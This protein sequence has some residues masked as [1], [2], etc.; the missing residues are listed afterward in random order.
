MK[1]PTKK[2]NSQ[3]VEIKGC[4]LADML[5]SISSKQAMTAAEQAKLNAD[6]APLVKKLQAFGGFA[7]INVQAKPKK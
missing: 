2:T 6:I 7:A 4:S 5:A 3:P 1:K